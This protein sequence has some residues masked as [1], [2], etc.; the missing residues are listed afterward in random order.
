MNPADLEKLLR[1]SYANYVV[2]TA[3]DYADP[4][5]KSRLIDNIR[6]ILPSIRH[7]P[8][9]R[10]IFGKIQEYEAGNGAMSPSNTMSPSQLTSTPFRS[11]GSGN[12]SAYNSPLSH[13][14]NYGSVMGSPTPHRNQHASLNMLAQPGQQTNGFSQGFPALGGRAARPSG[15]GHY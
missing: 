15:M 1:D 10:R 8:Y 6:P 3:M 13:G 14:S 7:T 2:Q 5:T 4:E 12:M 9:G 11:G